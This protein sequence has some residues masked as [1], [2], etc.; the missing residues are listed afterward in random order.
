[1]NG[2]DQ[3]RP[4]A[5]AEDQEIDGLFCEEVLREWL[6]NLE[7]QARKPGEALL[8]SRTISGSSRSKPLAPD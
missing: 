6:L 4:P 3:V 5:P 1:M 8:Q 2:K 7:A